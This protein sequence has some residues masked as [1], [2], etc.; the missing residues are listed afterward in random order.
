MTETPKNLIPFSQI[1]EYDEGQWTSEQLEAAGFL[2]KMDWEGGIDGLL[3]YG[4][5]EVFPEELQELA[6]VAEKA[7]GSLG[8]AIDKWAADRGVV[9]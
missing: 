2:H 5:S 9:Y 1:D 6:A 7:L 4:G 3:G 8:R